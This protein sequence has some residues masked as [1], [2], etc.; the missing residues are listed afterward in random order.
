V[1]DLFVGADVTA[2][3]CATVRVPVAAAPATAIAMFIR[4]TVGTTPVNAVPTPRRVNVTAPR[5]ST[6]MRPS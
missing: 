5:A 2:S 1:P 4:T 6:S 3:V